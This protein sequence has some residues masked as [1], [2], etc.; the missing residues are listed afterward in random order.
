VSAGRIILIVLGSI[1]ILLG[2]GLLTGGGFLLWADRT[3]RDDGYLTTPSERFATPTYA[4]TRTRLEID[5]SDFPDWFWNT[6]WF[7]KV[8][9]RVE[10]VGGRPVFI[11]IGPE[12][13]VDR[14]LGRVAHS[15]VEDIE[16]DPF[17]V[18][19]VPISGG[20][21]RQ[22]PLA[23]DFWV[24]SAAGVGRQTLTWKVRD[25]DWSAVLM[26]ADG[27]RPVAAEVDLGAKLSFLLWVAIGLLVGGVV[28]FAGSTGLVILA[29]RT[30]KPPAAP[31][32]P[33]PSGPA[34]GAQPT[35]HGEQPGREP[36]TA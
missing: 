23:Q 26:N 30:R 35:V 36:P 6:S 7:G 12:A 3:Q 27:S 1:G 32:T 4:M 16:L 5:D 19:Y 25:G 8:R 28:V 22:P 34:A 24:A 2:V 20:P 33:A 18:K 13:A 10:A 17:Q 15:D 11:G 9:L 29:A 31:P 14:Y 21:P